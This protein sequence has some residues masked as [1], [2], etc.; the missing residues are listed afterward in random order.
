MLVSTHAH[1]H[2]HIY[3]HTHAHAST[4]I[5]ILNTHNTYM[6]SRLFV[7]SLACFC[8]AKCI[9]SSSV[10]LPEMEIHTCSHSTARQMTYVS[11]IRMYVIYCFVQMV[12]FTMDHYNSLAKIF[13]MYVTVQAAQFIFT[14]NSHNYYKFARKGHTYQTSHL[15]T[16]CALQNSDISLTK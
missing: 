13:N 9:G 1:T 4:S 12:L 5:H 14:F 6:Y 11:Y 8:V 10:C 2:S 15:Q 7:L 16:Y 3:T